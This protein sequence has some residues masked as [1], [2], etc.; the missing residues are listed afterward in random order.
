MAIIP[1]TIS[2]VLPFMAVLLS[3]QEKISRW[4]IRSVNLGVAIRATP[5]EI[6]NRIQ[7]SWSCR[8]PAC[9]VTR[10]AY[11]RHPHFQQLRIIGSMRLVT[12]RAIL[13]DRG[14]LR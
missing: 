10:V 11:T 9:D 14:M 2:F 3:A 6:P 12:V 8:V 13:H 1:S 7:Q 5:I 4:M